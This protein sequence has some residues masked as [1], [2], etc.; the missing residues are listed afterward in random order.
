M[1]LVREGS[2]TIG[3]MT[4]AKTPE[5]SA[6]SKDWKPIYKRW[7]FWVIEVPFVVIFVGALLRIPALNEKERTE[8]VVAQIHAQR[9]TLADVNGEN[10]PPQPDPAKVDATI[11]GIDV[12]W[13]GIRDDVELA[14]F[15]KYPNSARIRAA[16]LQYAMELQ[17]ELTS[18]FN[19]ETLVATI[20][21][22]GRG[23]L[24]L[25]EGIPSDIPRFS[26]LQSMSEWL[27]VKKNANLFNQE[28]KRTS[29]I[30]DSR[31]QEVENLVFN[32]QIRKDKHEMIYRKYMTSFGSLSNE[33]CDIDIASL[34]N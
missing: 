7:W 25:N 3:I 5:N 8:Q 6:I 21:E 27:K 30:L 19:S 23:Y 2:D 4:T 17:R 18:V 31:T 29:A 1:R 34:A 14:I 10:L 13:N 26:D 9:L 28:H 22:E 12:N 15:K 11:E 24:C 20:Q 32:N 16:E 33:S